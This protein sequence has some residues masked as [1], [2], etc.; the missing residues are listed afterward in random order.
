MKKTQAIEIYDMI[1]LFHATG[2][3]LYLLK[4]RFPEVFRVM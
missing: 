3:F 2:F 4:T 1:N